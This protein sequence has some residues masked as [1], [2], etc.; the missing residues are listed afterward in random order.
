LLIVLVVHPDV[1][2]VP[3]VGSI[4]ILSTIILCIL[5]GIVAASGCGRCRTAGST[6]GLR[7][8]IASVSTVAAVVVLTIVVSA[9]VASVAAILRATLL[10]F[11]ILFANV[12]EQIDTELLRLLDHFWIRTGNVQIHW[13]IVL[14]S[15][16]RIIEA[17]ATSFDLDTASRLALDVFD[18]ST[19]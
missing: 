3:S 13:L 19:A 5:C 1:V 2:V 8:P 10:E 16:T 11:L 14:L 12:V 4:G 15:C 9:S 7:S 6:R 18:I 17:R